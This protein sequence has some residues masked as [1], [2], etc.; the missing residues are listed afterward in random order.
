VDAAKNIK[1]A[2]WGVYSSDPNDPANRAR[3]DLD[4]ALKSANITHTF[5]VY[6]DTHHAFFDDTGGAYNQEQ[7][8]AAWKD[9]LDWFAKYL[10]S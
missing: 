5:K 8:L 10:K 7:A 2:I 9:T 4:G 1:A 6:P 3:D